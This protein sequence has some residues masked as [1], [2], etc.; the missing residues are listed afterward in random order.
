MMSLTPAKAAIQICKRFF[1]Q[2]LLFP[3]K[4]Q[5]SVH[6]N[7]HMVKAP[8]CDFLNILLLDKGFKMFFLCLLRRE[9][10]N[11]L[12]LREKTTEV[13]SLFKFFK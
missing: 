3:F 8:L 11:D 2:P 4:K 13:D 5:I 10:R 6:W 12:I 1:L 7:A 9:I